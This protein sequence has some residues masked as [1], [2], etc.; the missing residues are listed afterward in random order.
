M[1]RRPPRLARRLRIWPGTRRWTRRSRRSSMPSARPYSFGALD[2]LAPEEL[3]SLQAA[4]RVTLR[5]A[6]HLVE[7]PG[8]PAGWAF[9]DPVILQ[10]Q[11]KASRNNARPITQFAERTPSLTARLSQ[12]ARFLDAGCGVGW[13]SITMAERWPQLSVDGIDIHEPA[14]RL[15]EEN[16]VASTAAE[17]LRFHHRN[18]L[19]LEAVNSYAVAFWGAVFF[20]GEVVHAALPLLHRAIEPGGWLFAAAYKDPDTPLEKAL[21]DL[22]TTLSGG[23]VWSLDEMSRLLAD[24]GF[25]VI[26]EIGEGRVAQFAARKR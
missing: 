8:R 2:D 16:R 18:I 11:G 10:T 15:A 7:N 9:D 21:I 6:L 13:I 20:P 24:H 5:I 14:L 19:D 4:V 26:E 12:P 22:R 1:S 25:E 3:R 23:R 17:R